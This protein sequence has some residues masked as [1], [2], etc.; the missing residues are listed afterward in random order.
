[1]TGSG[2]GPGSGSRRDLSRRLAAL[3]AGS[4]ADGPRELGWFDLLRHAKHCHEHGEDALRREE[5]F[6]EPVTL[7]SDDVEWA[8]RLRAASTHAGDEVID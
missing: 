3:E 4:G 7:P 1:M 2:P 6:S 5:F 8:R